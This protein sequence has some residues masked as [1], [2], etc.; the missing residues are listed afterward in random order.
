MEHKNT[1]RIGHDSWKNHKYLGKFDHLS[2]N[3]RSTY[4]DI[5]TRHYLLV[6]I[7]SG[8]WSSQNG[9]SLWFHRVMFEAF[10]LS[11]FPILTMTSNS[12][13]QLFGILTSNWP[14][15]CWRHDGR[16]I[17]LHASCS[18]R[19]HGFGTNPGQ[20]PLPAWWDDFWTWRSQE[21][22]IWKKDEKGAHGWTGPWLLLKVPSLFNKPN[23]YNCSTSIRFS[24]DKVSLD[25]ISQ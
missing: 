25:Q 21:T 1:S 20:K 10:A 4:R 5:Y 24:S 8:E 13:S 2:T 7:V 17:I 11:L 9:S 14:P 6:E 12:C 3:P 16:Q 15:C 19:K 18:K 22:N 23:M